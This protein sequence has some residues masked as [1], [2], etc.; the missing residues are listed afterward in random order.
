MNGLSNVN[1]SN[2]DL[3]QNENEEETAQQRSTI[4]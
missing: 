1:I 4:K 3:K 2:L